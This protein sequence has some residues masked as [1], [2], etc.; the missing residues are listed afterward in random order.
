MLAL[1]LDVT[2]NERV[3]QAAKETESTFGRCD[4]LINNSGYMDRPS[5][6]TEVDPDK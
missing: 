3:A 2:N 6:M 4:I 5:K 1:K